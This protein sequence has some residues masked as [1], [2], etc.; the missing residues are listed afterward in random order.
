MLHK[1]WSQWVDL[2]KVDN[3]QHIIEAI[4]SSP[5]LDGDPGTWQ[6]QVYESDSIT[7][8]AIA[9]A[10]PD[11]MRWGNVR[12]MHQSKAVGTVLEAKVLKSFKVDGRTVDNPLWVKIRIVDD[13]AWKKVK[14]GV[15]K[16]LSIGGRTISAT[17]K[18]VGGRLVRVITA[19][20]M[21]EISLADRPQN[22]D[23]QI[24]LWKGFSMDPELLNQLLKAADPTKAVAMLQ[25]LRN[26][27]ELAGE[28]D[29]AELYTNA[30]RLVQQA[31][32]NAAPDDEPSADETTQD[33]ADAA[34]DGTDAVM[35]AAKAGDLVKSGGAIKRFDGKDWKAV[36]IHKAGRVFKSAN[37]NA[38]HGVIQALAK[39]LANAGDD[40]AN[41]VLK[42]YGGGD[43]VAMTALSGDILKAMQP[44]LAKV[45][46]VLTTLDGRIANLERQPAPGG[47]AMR[48]AGDKTLP[49]QGQNNNNGDQEARIAKRKKLERDLPELKR[50][51]ATDPQPAAR[52]DYAAQAKQLEAEIAA[53]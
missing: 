2:L 47:P 43:P 46:G 49:G 10:L 20:K 42:A 28:M 6:G 12:E 4:A 17:L 16:G 45:L 11:Y 18:K 5:A 7:P 32:G 38:M 51:A 31:A 41:K 22:S 8:E 26:D 48:A 30:I 21:T 29:Q 33:Q 25:Q 44:E 36:T 34:P 35:Q 3:E 19:L 24:L 23:A 14:E 15:Y 37:A 13:E 39:M 27:A 50:L 1:G 52:A 53:L 9:A 40:T